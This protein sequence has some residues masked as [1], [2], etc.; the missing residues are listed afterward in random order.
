MQNEIPCYECN[1]NKP[2]LGPINPFS[3]CHY[4]C[5]ECIKCGKIGNLALGP[6]DWYTD[7]HERCLDCIVCGKNS[8]TENELGPVDRINKCHSGCLKIEYKNSSNMIL[9]KSSILPF[10]KIQKVEEEICC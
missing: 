4:D 8:S 3:G 7:H 10:F 5:H 1:K 2:E 9:L 6:V